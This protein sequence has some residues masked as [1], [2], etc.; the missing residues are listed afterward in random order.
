MVGAGAMVINN[1][2][3]I[4]VVKEKYYKK[5]HWKLPGGY[6]DPGRIKILDSPRNIFKILIIQVKVYQQQS[7]EKSWKKQELR[8]NL[9]QWYHFAIS[10]PERMVGCLLLLTCIL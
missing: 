3:E 1:N 10:N 7:D 9:F 5:P 4:L 2:N 8:Q 6:V